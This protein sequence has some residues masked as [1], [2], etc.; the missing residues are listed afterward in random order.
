MSVDPPALAWCKA[1]FAQAALKPARRFLR[2]RGRSGVE[3]DHLGSGPAVP[4]FVTVTFAVTP[5]AVRG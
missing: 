4:L 5:L 3:L 1:T 2:G